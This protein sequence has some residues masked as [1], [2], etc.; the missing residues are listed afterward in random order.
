M[1]A[2]TAWLAVWLGL[3]SAAQFDFS[4]DDLT[5]TKNDTTSLAGFSL[6]TVKAGGLTRSYYV[7]VPSSYHGGRIPVL[8][9]FHG[10]GLT[11]LDMEKLTHISRESDKHGFLLILPQ[12]IDNH[13]NDG[14]KLP[15]R[16]CDDVGF[17]KQL[18]ATEL[19]RKW[20]IDSAR[21]YSTGISNGGTLSQYLAMKLPGKLAAI[22]SVAATVTVNM[23]EEGP[24]SH[25]VPILY[26]LG[27]SDPIVPYKGGTVFLGP[28]DLGESLSADKS[29]QF[30]VQAN[31]CRP[32]PKITKL[33]AVAPGDPTSVERKEFKPGQGNNEVVE[34]I[35]EGGG[36]AWPGGTQYLPR[37]LVG[38]VSQQINANK[39][40]LDFFDRHR[41]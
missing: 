11:A 13:W 25:P 23:N 14:R 41:L 27:T 29:V 17:V 21:I 30:W 37:A 20:Q 6:N 33:P 10:G 34:Y 32:V 36:H 7:H 24:P 16:T 5:D 4:L 35:I 9:V 38:T 2:L 12:G 18:L 40:I 8:L 15:G 28:I 1:L 22:A 19:K 39:I 26:L 3:P 31:R